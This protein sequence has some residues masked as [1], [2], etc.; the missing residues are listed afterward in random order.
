[1]SVVAILGKRDTFPSHNGHF[2][3]TFLKM[4][5]QIH[6]ATRFISLLGAKYSVLLTLTVEKC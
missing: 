5:F 4:E 1:M 3:G 6:L 2:K